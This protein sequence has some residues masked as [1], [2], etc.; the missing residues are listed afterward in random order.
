MSETIEY[1]SFLEVQRVY[2]G[3]QIFIRDLGNW[4]IYERE[5]ESVKDC[6]VNLR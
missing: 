1:Y 3:S 2:I 5:K 6:K 4:S